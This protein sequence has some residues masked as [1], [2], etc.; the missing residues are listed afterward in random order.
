VYR[1]AM[2]R[3]W[4]ALIV[5]GVLGCKEKAKD[6]RPAEKGSASSAPID[7]PPVKI[8]GPAITPVVTNS[9]TFFVPKDAPWWG[10]MVFGCYA[11]A[12]TLQPGSTP[13]APFTKISPAVEPAMRAAD[14][15]L[16]KDLG[17]IGAWGCGD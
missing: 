5:V 3:A 4:V 1:R 8:D 2:K 10:E 17:A 15:D 12:I 13:S 6:V 9:I 11:G 7:K 14:I 16:D